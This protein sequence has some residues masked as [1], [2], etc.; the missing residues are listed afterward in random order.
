[1]DPNPIA[2]FRKNLRPRYFYNKFIGLFALIE[3]LLLSPR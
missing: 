1:M 3:S 2:G